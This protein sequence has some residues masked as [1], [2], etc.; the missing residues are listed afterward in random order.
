VP[1]RRRG[2]VEQGVARD[3]AAIT[4]RDPDLAEGGL[5]M[6]ALQLAKELDDP[7][8]SATSKSMCGKTLAD[9][10]ATLRS[11]APPEAKRDS[12]DDLAAARA[13]RRQD[14]QAQPGS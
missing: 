3:I 7:G 10:L 6:A 9:T 5:A 2:P 8:N 12:I 4:R 13:R 11:L 14:A 1:A